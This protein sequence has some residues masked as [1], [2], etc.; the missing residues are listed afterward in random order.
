MKNLN[1][2]YELASNNEIDV[3]SFDLPINK[4]ISIMDDTGDCYIA[5]DAM[6]IQS[7]ADEKS[8]LAHELGHCILGAFYN[9]DSTADIRSRYEA[10]AN[11]WA[12]KNLIPKNE[13]IEA[14]NIGYKESW[15]LAEYFDVPEWMVKKAAE[16][17]CYND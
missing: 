15:E 4:S 8:I 13:I 10:R 5:I 9:K 16:Y 6:Q 7:V 12:F 3:Y 11:R 1:E 17:Y 2:L 14:V